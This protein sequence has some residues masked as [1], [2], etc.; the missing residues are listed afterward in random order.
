MTKIDASESLKSLTPKTQLGAFEESW[1]AIREAIDRKVTLF[2]I[3]ENLKEAGILN[4]SYPTF[5]R[6]TKKLQATEIEKRTAS[7]PAAAHGTSVETV[8]A[9]AADRPAESAAEKD[10][11]GGDKAN[12][13]LSPSSSALHEARS[14]ATRKDY[15]KIARHEERKSRK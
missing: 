4:V 14:M 5:T 11:V 12:Q 3:W 13:I 6:F 9:E 8:L 15:S 10:Q 1:P 7:Q 2:A